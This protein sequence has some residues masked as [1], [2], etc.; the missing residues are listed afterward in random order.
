MPYKVTHE[1]CLGCWRYVQ[2][3]RQYLK[4]RFRQGAQAWHDK[5]G[6]ESCPYDPESRNARK[7]M[8]WKMGWNYAN[9]C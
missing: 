3:P 6:I 8:W 1:Y 7:A 2:E 4:A 5:K 9:R